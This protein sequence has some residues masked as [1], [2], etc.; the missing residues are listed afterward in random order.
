MRAARRIQMIDNNPST[1][2]GLGACDRSR[3]SA[4]IHVLIDHQSNDKWFHEPFAVSPSGN[5]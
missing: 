3:T 2:L 1:K 4:V 5:L